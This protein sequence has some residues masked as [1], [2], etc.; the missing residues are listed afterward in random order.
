MNDKIWE[1][2]PQPTVE[3]EEVLLFY[4]T[5]I[6][7]SR[8][9]ENRAL[10][11]DIVVW[12]KRKKHILSFSF[13]FDVAVPN[14]GGINEAERTKI[15]KYQDLK[16]DVR[17]AWAAKSAEIIPVTVRANGLIKRNLENYLNRIPS[18]PKY[19]EIQESA[20][21]DTV[22]VLKRALGFHGQ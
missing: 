6:P 1:H 22:S 5:R 15:A 17:Q 10:R 12:N 16:N 3:N 19:Q 14:D 4:D 18:C 9:I 11:P 7:T 21:R 20:V 13:L 8:F 2:E